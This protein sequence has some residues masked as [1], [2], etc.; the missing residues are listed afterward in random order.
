[1]PW[2][3]PGVIA[4][5]LLA[6][7][8]LIYQAAMALTDFNAISIR[9]GIHGRRLARR[10]AGA[11]RAGQ[12]GGSGESSRAGSRSKEVHYA[13]PAVL[14]QLLGGAAPDLLAF[15]VLWAVL[16]VGL[17]A[18]LGIERRADAQPPR[19]AAARALADDLHPAVGHPGVRRRADLAAHLRAAATAGL[20]LAQ[21]LPAGVNLPNWFENPNTTLLILLVAATWYGFPLIMLAATAGLKLV[22]ARCMT[23]RPWTAPAAG[24]QFRHV[25]WP[26]LLPLVAPA[27]IV[28][29]IFAFNQF[30]LFYTMHVSPPTVTFAT[31]SYYLLQ[32]DRLLRR[33]VRGLGGDQHLHGA[34]ADWV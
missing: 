2:L 11:D 4:L 25:T 12:T 34:G 8:P 14:G 32:P 15:N 20:V 30:Y 26:L 19:G 1:M 9:D 23:R 7:F 29:G 5:C 21:R 13:G 17:Q 28:R 18:A 10:L 22:P 3:V 33:A 16:S 27:I 31:A 6:L 24:G